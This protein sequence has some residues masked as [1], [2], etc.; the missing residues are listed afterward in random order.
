M[1]I[2]SSDISHLLIVSKDTL[3]IFY[4]QAYAANY[5]SSPVAVVEQFW[6]KLST[7]RDS[8]RNPIKKI[9][10]QEKIKILISA[11]WNDKH[12]AFLARQTP[13]LSRSANDSKCFAI[14]L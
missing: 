5:T 12:H 4:L 10:L 13:R 11:P 8:L 14:V 2:R 6:V 3:Y 9:H 7:Y 1:G